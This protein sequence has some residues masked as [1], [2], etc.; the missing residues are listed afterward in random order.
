MTRNILSA[1]ILSACLISCA[2]ND[3]NEDLLP[4]PK[5]EINN[6][7]AVEVEWS[8]SVGSGVENYFSRLKPAVGYEQVYAA[9]RVGYVSAF[10]IKDGDEVWTTDLRPAEESYWRFLGLNFSPAIRV[11][12]LVASYEKVFIGC[13]NGELI[14]LDVK[15]GKELWRTKVSGEILSPPIAEESKVI[16]NLGSGN[17]VAFNAVDGEQIWESVA[18]VPSLTL[19]GASSPAYAQG[20][21]FVGSA[22]GK[23]LTYA[24]ANGQLAWDVSVANAQ[25]ATELARIVDIDSTPIFSGTNLFALSAGGALVSVDVRTSRVVWKRDYRGYEN[26]THSFTSLY[27]S[28]DHSHIYALD[29]KTGVEKW[30][31]LVL[32]NRQVT[33]GT[34]FKDYYVVGDFDGYLYFFDKSNG[35]LKSMISVSGDALLAQPV[36][37]DE[38]LLIQTRDGDIKALKINSK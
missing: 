1:V 29:S 35:E 12:G 31:N 38:L 11:S 22:T 19:R 17:T 26:I 13:E 7:V 34:V 23:I 21:V 14:A 28:D 25:G 5:P 8:E 32:R 37:A 20:G 6:Q 2:S 9:D 3:E 4:A 24:A 27:L 36:V 16:V 15:T 33:A 18:D 10:S 30:S